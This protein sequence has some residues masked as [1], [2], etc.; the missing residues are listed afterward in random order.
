[1]PWHPGERSALADA[2]EAAGPGAP[3]RCD[4]WATEHLAAHV[5]VRD[6]GGLAAVGLGVGAL[7]HRPTELTVAGVETP[8]TQGGYLDLVHRVRSGPPPWSPLRWAGDTVHL[9]ELFVH[10]ED[11]RRGRGRRAAAPRGLPAGERAALWAALLRVAPRLYADSPVGVVLAWGERDR[12]VR[13]PGAD[14][15]SDVVVRGDVGELVLHASG[16]SAVAD[17]ELVGPAEPVAR[18]ARVRPR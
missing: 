14:P 13:R 3:T 15:L 1:M 18:L 11:V 2:L 12:R 6:G 4:G 16:R 5:V 10:T 9:L 7:T 8:V 17:V